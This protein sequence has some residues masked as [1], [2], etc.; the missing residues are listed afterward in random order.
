MYTLLPVVLLLQPVLPEEEEEG[1]RRERENG[2][3]RREE[4]G[5]RREEG[6]VEILISTVDT[7]SEV[8]R[9]KCTSPHFRGFLIALRTQ[10]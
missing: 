2:G 6:G 9:I 10:P 5:A 8:L 7:N 4:E 3:G 1:S